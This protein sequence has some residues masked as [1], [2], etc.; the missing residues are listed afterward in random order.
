[1]PILWIVLPV[2]LLSVIISAAY[3]STA[4]TYCIA[5][6]LPLA[7]TLLVFVPPVLWPSEPYS[8]G[9]AIIGSVM[10]FVPTVAVCLI[11]AA[12]LTFLKR[13]ADRRKNPN[14]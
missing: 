12:V 9:W 7:L 11:A 13:R 3:L 14:I 10:L 1:M 4:A 8:P 6:F 5:L 2:C